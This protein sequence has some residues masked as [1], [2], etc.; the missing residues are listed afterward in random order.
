[1]KLHIF[2]ASGSGVTTLEKRLAQLLN[3]K[4]FDTD[5]YFW[6]KTEP[7]FTQRREPAER[8]Q[9]ISYDLHK[10]HKWVLGGSIIDWGDNLFPDFDLVIFLYLPIELRMERLEMRELEKYGDIIYTDEIRKKQFVNFLKWTADY[11]Y[12]T[13]VAKRTLSAH[14]SWLEKLPKPALEI[15]GDF[16]FDEKVQIV[17]KRLNIADI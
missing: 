15:I 6:I 7:P 13:G 16:S 3:A 10:T 5:D 8:N 9:L 17:S 2:G 11:D 14:R 12:N 4:Y 1:M